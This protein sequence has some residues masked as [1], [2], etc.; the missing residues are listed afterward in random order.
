[1]V[2]RLLSIFHQ[3]IAK[4]FLLFTK[5]LMYKPIFLNNFTKLNSTT[6]KVVNFFKAK[7]LEKFKEILFTC[8]RF[9]EALMK[10]SIYFN[11]RIRDVVMK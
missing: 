11:S 8:M 6:E 1:M 9:K 10:N 2:E 3:N 4:Y 5:L 7:F